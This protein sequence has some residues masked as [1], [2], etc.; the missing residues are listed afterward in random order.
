MS[1]KSTSGPSTAQR[2]YDHL[3][4][5]LESG[6][7]G[8]G[9]RLVTRELAGEIGSSLNPVREALSRLAS[10]GFVVHVPGAGASVRGPD[11]MEIRELYGLREA[12]ESY[13]AGEAARHISEEELQQLEEI[14]AEWR[15]TADSLRATGQVL[16]AEALVRWR[17]SNERFHRILVDAARNRLLAKTVSDHRVLATIF[18]Q[19]GE[20]H[21]DVTAELA[22]QVASSHESLV[23]A[24][25]SRDSEAARSQVAALIRVGREHVLRQF[26]AGA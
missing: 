11:R 24:L 1:S 8:P 22:E 19:H 26:D 25:R 15:S 4:A 16:V 9:A 6:E 23:K 20:L 18:R 2:A 17:H 10:E 14:C 3:R 5:K 12:I 7:L 21:I 13:A